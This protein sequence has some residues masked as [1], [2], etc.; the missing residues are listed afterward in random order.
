MQYWVFFIGGV[1]G[2]GFA[3]LLE[4][5]NNITPADGKLLWR[6]RP[7]RYANDSVGFYSASYLNH[8]FLRFNDN[9]IKKDEVEPKTYYR[10]LVEQ[11]CNTVIADHPLI[12]DFDKTFKYWDLFEQDQHKIFLYSTDTKRITEEFCEKNKNLQDV[13]NGKTQLEM[14]EGFSNSKPPLYW[15]PDLNYNTY[16]NIDQVWKDWDYLN[17]ILTSIGIDLD[18]KYYEEYLDIAKRRSIIDTDGR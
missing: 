2:D 7:I 6:V 1:G 15:M 11:G 9:H 5:A 12:Y 10:N 17:G 3:N 4:H 16:I 8:H 13:R 14:M 18:R